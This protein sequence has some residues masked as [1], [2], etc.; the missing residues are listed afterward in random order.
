MPHTSDL[1]LN[2]ERMLNSYFKLFNE[3]IDK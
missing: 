2:D 1:L 3:P